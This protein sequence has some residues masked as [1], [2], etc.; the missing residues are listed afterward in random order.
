MTPVEIYALCKLNKMKKLSITDYVD[1]K[2]ALTIKIGNDITYDDIE[3]KEFI[4]EET[5]FDGTNNIDTGVS[6]FDEDRD[7]TLAIDF[8]FTSGCASN[9]VLAQC[10]QPITAGGFKL[11]YS[12]S[13]RFTYDGTLQ[14]G[15]SSTDY[16][17]IVV[18]RHQKSDDSLTLYY[19]NISGD[20]KTYTLSA[21][22]KDTF[23]N[24]LVFG[25][26]KLNDGS[27]SDYA[28]GKIY[29]AKLWYC[30]LGEKTCQSIASWI[31][32]ELTME[33]ANFN[34]Y[35]LSEDNNVNCSVTLIAANLLGRGVRW[36]TTYTTVGGWASSYL[37]TYMNGRIYNSIPNQIRSLMKNVQ[38]KGGAGNNDA[39]VANMTY[40]ENY[41]HAPSWKEIAGSTTTLGSPYNDETGNAIP[42]MTSY[43]NRKKTP[44]GSESAQT[45]WLRTPYNY[46]GSSGTAYYVSNVNY[47][48]YI[49]YNYASA[50]YSY[51]MLI[52]FSF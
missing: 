6:L 22:E 41:I 39:T 50:A 36:N 32:E 1:Y 48:G 18:L 3:Q 14:T 13:P 10:L 31:R 2:D 27:Y 15:I 11:W 25:S 45:Y 24:T 12:T 30:D 47:N 8:S 9:G 35:P 38:L 43:N 46:T 52:E 20:I 44:I 23:A 37:R 28:T 7:F 16:R 33:V 21:M 17:E 40:S 49:N 4:T 51:Y 34:T 5:V 42:W 29:W 19:S 26:A